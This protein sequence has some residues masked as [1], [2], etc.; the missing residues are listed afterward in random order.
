M[1]DLAFKRAETTDS[2]E[3]LGLLR[4]IAEWLEGK[5]VD[6]WREFLT[7]EGGAK[8]A[9]RFR[10]GEVYKVLLDG[11]VAG[12]F[13]IQWDD[14]FWHPEKNDGMACWVHT[15]GV[16]P[17]S[18]GRGIGKRILSHIEGI[19]KGAGKKCVRLDCNADN[20][21]LCGFYESQGF[22]AAGA[23][24]WA[25]KDWNVRLYEKEL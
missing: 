1:N 22:K 24:K 12:M 7:D 23:K 9:K 25:E 21:K 6:Q 11:T 13:V 5:G 15:L 10:E 3:I 2:P 4:R 20:T 8:L 18:R 17:A 16:D 19:A 14:T